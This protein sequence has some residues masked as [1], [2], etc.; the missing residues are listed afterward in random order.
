MKYGLIGAK[1]GHSFSREIHAKIAD[2]PYE[3]AE[4]DETALDAFFRAKDFCGVNVTIPYKQT[5]MRY[6]D[7]TDEAAAR[8]GAVNTVVNRGGRLY[9]YNTDYFGAAAM[10]RH[11]GLELA[12]KRVLILGSGGT[13]KTMCAVARDLGAAEVLTVSRRAGGGTVSYDEAVT[14]Y[15]DA[16]IIINTTPVGMFPKSDACPI[17][18][19]AFDRLEGVADAVYNPLSTVLVRRAKARGLMACGGLYMLAAQAVYASALFFD[20][21]VKDGVADE[22]YRAVRREKQNIV[23]V[24]MPS[25]GKSSV[26][27]RLAQKTGRP[28]ADSDEEIVR[29]SGKSIPDIFAEQGEAGFRA[30]ERQVISDLSMQQGMVLATGG[31]AILN[32]D[33]VFDLK[34]NGRLFFLDRPPEKL[35]STSDRPLAANRQALEKLYRERKDK[36]TAAADIRIPGEGTVAEVADLVWEAFCS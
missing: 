31:G 22:V 12:G 26:G 1:L 7:E 13:S 29:K 11:A 15:S 23:L 34:A 24:G 19:D 16:R 8:I 28:F 20:S 4:M 9:G 25:S 36:Y 14:R 21:P 32:P 10:L 27:A 5:V 35:L 30:L 18:I 3:L 17:D 2:Y 33:N 6:L